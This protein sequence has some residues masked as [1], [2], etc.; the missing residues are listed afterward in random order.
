MTTLASLNAI[1]TW[2]WYDF[3]LTNVNMVP[4]ISG[5]YCL[6]INNQIIYIG[7]SINLQE[8]LTD[9]YY[10]S[11]P[12]IKQARQFAIEPCSNYKERERQRLLQY[13]ADNGKLP[14]C[15]DQI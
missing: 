14:A 6:G 5:V 9:H 2:T 13:Q 7:S 8:R 3:T 15:N 11:D 1:Q 4:Q 10:S 12:C